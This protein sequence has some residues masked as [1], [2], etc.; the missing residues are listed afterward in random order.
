MQKIWVVVLKG[1]GRVVEDMKRCEEEYERTSRR[2][3]WRAGSVVAVSR[4]VVL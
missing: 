2:E 3:L 4:T 1:K